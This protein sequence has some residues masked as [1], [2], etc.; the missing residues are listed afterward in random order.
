MAENHSAQPGTAT[1]ASED[2]IADLMRQLSE[3]TS[4][5]VSQEIELAKAEVSEKGKA[6]GQG[7]GMFGGAAGAG[8]YAVGAL[9]ATA[10]AG[11]SEAVATWLAAGIV[12][13]VLLAVAGVMALRGKSKVQEA[14]PPAPEQTR[15]SVK[16]DLEWTKARAK[17][18]RR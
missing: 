17:S 4:R 11:L 2:S 7:A 8:F 18:G 14:M 3:Q 13:V 5:L 1:P 6:A 9:I 10:I 16:E 15:E 12:T